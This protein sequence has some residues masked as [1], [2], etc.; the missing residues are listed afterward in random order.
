MELILP[1]Q[2]VKDFMPVKQTRNPFQPREATSLVAWGYFGGR[3]QPIFYI[4]RSISGDALLRGHRR[5]TRHG[6]PPG[7]IR[8]EVF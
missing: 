4:R 5:F 2:P 1:R 6:S 8:S 7:E 3:H